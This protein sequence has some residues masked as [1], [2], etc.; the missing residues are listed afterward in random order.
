MG[1]VWNTGIFSAGLR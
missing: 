1:Y